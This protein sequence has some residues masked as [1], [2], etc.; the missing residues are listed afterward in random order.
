MRRF[1]PL[2]VM[3]W[4]GLFLLMSGSDIGWAYNPFPKYESIV[5]NVAF[6]KKV[7]SRYSTSQGII[8][9]NLD[10]NIIYEVVELAPFDAP[11]SDAINSKRKNKAIE[12]YSGLL[13]RLARNP[14]AMDAE[15][16]RVARLF[17]AKGNSKTYRR[18]AER[19]RCQLG[20]KDRFR[21]G[22]I[23]SGA[24]LEEIRAILR[25]EGLPEDLCYLPHVESSF[26]TNAYSKFG[27]AGMW[28][29]MPA[30]GKRFMRVDYAVDERLDPILSSRAAAKLLKENYAALG[31]WALALT[32]YNHGTGG[33]VRAKAI[34]GNYPA[35]QKYYQSKSFKFASR[36]FYSEF[37]A[38]REIASNYQTYFG[39]IDLDRPTPTRTFTVKQYV[40]LGDLCR[41]YGIES[42][43]IKEMNPALRPPVIAGRKLIPKGYALRLPSGGK[44]VSPSLLAEIPADLYKSDQK[45]SRFYTV[46]AGDTA[47]KIARAHGIKLDELRAANELDH[48]ATLYPRQALRIPGPGEKTG[49]R[50]KKTTGGKEPS[51]AMATVA[52]AEK[53]DAVKP[54]KSKEQLAYPKPI[55]ASVI[56]LGRTHVVEKD[57]AAVAGAESGSGDRPNL[58]V[59]TADVRIQKKMRVG[60]RPVALI[61]VEVEENLGRYAE[62]ARVS[63]SQ[64]R[65]LNRLSNSGALR[66]GQPLKIPLQH[67][68]VA[69]FEEQRYEY[70]KRL[71]EDFFAVYRITGLQ[72][73]QVGP[74]ETYWKLCYEK[75]SIPFWLLKHCNPEVDLSALG[76]KQKLI[77]PSIDRISGDEPGVEGNAEVDW[78]Y[79]P[80]AANMIA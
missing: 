25:A 59:V 52:Q 47:S 34:Y 74:G 28:Q 48:R 58:E 53:A 78:R 19:I 22:L 17:G 64:I 33:M 75:F 57:A 7:Y 13:R 26:N 6:W 65:K 31:C 5:P 37:L 67:T 66:L 29:F 76:I 18:A 27:A 35:I 46:R 8:H 14:K 38:A 60:G 49:R 30:T 68:S 50:S 24:Y 1:V 16:R 23:R 32:A 15:S 61:H 77:I 56:P 45:H 44:N 42:R 62:W 20:L 54:G 21:A 73:Y 72:P 80:E 40:A 79:L 69:A 4:F 55:L 2:N 51:V 36:N 3:A 43:R 39:K 11:G 41:H 71:Q 70:H 9:D 63:V 12:K 10:L